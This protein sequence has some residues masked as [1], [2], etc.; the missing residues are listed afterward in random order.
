MLGLEFISVL[1]YILFHFNFF[2][3]EGDHIVVFFDFEVSNGF[4]R[5]FGDL[6]FS[7]Y[8]IANRAKDPEFIASFDKIIVGF[9]DEVL[10][11]RI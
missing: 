5:L 9:S 7:E 6:D 8:P 11:N 4:F 10:V 2:L 1:F 3:G